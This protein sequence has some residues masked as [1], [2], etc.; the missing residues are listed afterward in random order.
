MPSTGSTSYDQPDLA[1][2]R[3]DRHAAVLVSE[4]LVQR[5]CDGPDINSD[6]RPLTAEHSLLAQFEGKMILEVK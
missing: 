4:F 2:A 1:A 3:S 6:N 5:N